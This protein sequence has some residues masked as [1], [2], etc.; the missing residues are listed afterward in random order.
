MSSVRSQH[1]DDGEVDGDLTPMIDMVF[2]LIIFFL[3][4]SDFSS[5]TIEPVILPKAIMADTEKE[6]VTDRAIVINV[7]G[8]GKIKIDGRPYDKET[9]PKVLEIRADAAGREVNP[10]DPNGKK[11]S[12]LIV[13]LRADRYARYEHVQTVF[14]ACALNGIYKTSIGA[15]KEDLR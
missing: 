9:L 1:A 4:V 2:Q 10:H 11:I 6:K 15:V 12:K 7:L 14:K 13:T 5:V 3:I 8:D